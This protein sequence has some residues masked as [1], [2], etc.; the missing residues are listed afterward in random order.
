[1]HAFVEKDYGIKL[2]MFL[3]SLSMDYWV[4]TMDPLG[5]ITL[6]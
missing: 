5:K 4:S 1:M 2:E 6:L 3:A